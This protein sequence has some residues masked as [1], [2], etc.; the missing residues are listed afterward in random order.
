MKN[1][2]ARILAGSIAALLAVQS[3]SANTYNA[4]VG[5]GSIAGYNPAGGLNLGTGASNVSILIQGNGTNN[6]LTFSDKI[7][8]NGT[9]NTITVGNTAWLNS[10][11]STSYS[12]GSFEI[13]GTGNKLI[14]NGGAKVSSW[15]YST[16]RGTNNEIQVTGPGSLLGM[17][18]DPTGNDGWG[19]YTGTPTSHKLTIASGGTVLLDGS[20]WT[21]SCD[22]PASGNYLATI[23]GAGS[24]LNTKDMAF[25]D[26]FASA[27]IGGILRAT[28]G[29]AWEVRQ[30]D[31]YSYGYDAARTTAVLSHIKIDGGV[32]SYQGVS[33]VNMGESITAVAAGVKS[34]FNLAWAGN[35]ALRLNGTS[36]A[37]GSL[38]FTA[39][40]A[41][42]SDT[43][44]YTLANN[45]GAKNY[46]RLELVNG[47]T[48]VARAITIDGGNGGSILF[49]STTATIANGVTLSG[50]ATMTAEGNAS[51]LTG[52]ITGSGSLT[53][54]GAGTLTLQS[55]NTH[56]GTT[57][58]SFGTL[59]LNHVN[60]LQS[61]TLDTGTA[62]AQNVTF[63]VAGTQTYNL[64]GLSGADALNAGANSLSIGAN[65]FN[66]TSTGA[67]TAA[68]VTK[69]GA[70][71][72]DLNGTNQ[73]YNTLTASAGTTN[74]N[75]LL[76][77]TPG[78]AVVSVT[79]GGAKLRFGTVSQTLSSLTIGAG[80]T[81]VFTS[82]AASG[83]FGG[84]GKAAGFG[85][86]VVPEPG[87]LGLLLIGALGVLHRRRAGC[88]CSRGQ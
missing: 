8:I 70:G 42:A 81:V 17:S 18:I 22:T 64:G 20:G 36:R 9:N 67:I 26:D 87:T 39:S 62:G 65:N 56:T 82:G 63:T 38:V 51:S 77:V 12:P 58:V 83:A 44:S 27:N 14:I 88:S 30:S 2:L 52:V 35:N 29:G 40:S 23:D 47:T 79:A 53:K 41:S 57:L 71:I 31:L 80:S 10:T 84:G 5:D 60:A 21:A 33:G 75:G 69:V 4:T 59:A 55:A 43:G 32:L 1:T 11:N 73:L 45:L 46:T 74:V 76:G 16:I 13:S 25:F 28:N 68:A 86:A 3:V 85:A 49:D 66:T 54:T 6:T 34:A 61:S 24:T 72:L 78:T 7:V 50:A 15:G 48:S 19:T 37:I